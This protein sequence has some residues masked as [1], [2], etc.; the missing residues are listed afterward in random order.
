MSSRVQGRDTHGRRARGSKR[1]DSPPNGTKRDAGRRE[2]RGLPC[3]IRSLTQEHATTPRDGKPG[4]GV[5]RERGGIHWDIP[6]VL[7]E[8]QLQNKK[9]TRAVLCAP[10]LPRGLFSKIQQHTALRLFLAFSALLQ[11]SQHTPRALPSATHRR[12]ASDEA[13]SSDLSK[14]GQGQRASA[15]NSSRNR[16]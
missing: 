11:I 1:H 4:S 5:M 14:S 8:T 7:G 2:T 10:P 6:S 12:G 13:D 9:R 3:S 15:R 16:H